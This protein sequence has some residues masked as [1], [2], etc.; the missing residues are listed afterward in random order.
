MPSINISLNL[1][2]LKYVTLTVC[3]HRA[4]FLTYIII[5]CDIIPLYVI[6]IVVKLS[7]MSFNCLLWIPY[8]RKYLRNIKFEDPILILKTKQWFKETMCS[9]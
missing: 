5:V 6:L 2:F 9:T 4:G 7:T 1:Y 8:T 3:T